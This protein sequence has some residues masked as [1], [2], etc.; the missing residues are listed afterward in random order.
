MEQ[1]HPGVFKIPRACSMEQVRMDLGLPTLQQRAETARLRWMRL[2]LQNKCYLLNRLVAKLVEIWQKPDH[3]VQLRKSSALVQHARWPMATLGLATQ[4]GLE[5]SD[6]EDMFRVIPM[7]CCD[8]MWNPRTGRNRGMEE[9]DDEFL[10][11][12]RNDA[13]HGLLATEAV[14]QSSGWLN[15][16]KSLVQRRMHWVRVY[17]W[18]RKVQLDNRLRDWRMIVPERPIP[19]TMEMVDFNAWVLRQRAAHLV[20]LDPQGMRWKWDVVANAV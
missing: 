14:V 17:R 16:T 2:G 20:E 18:M 8:S 9:G 6:M 7:M 13:E 19:R 10:Q 12:V 3:A 1:V 11:F 4:M 5:S 15:W